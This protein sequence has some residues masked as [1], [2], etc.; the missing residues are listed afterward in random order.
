MSNFPGD[1]TKAEELTGGNVKIL[2]SF[3]AETKQKAPSLA[4][5]EKS[6]VESPPVSSPKKSAG[7]YNSSTK[8]QFR[9]NAAPK[10]EKKFKCTLCDFSTERI[11]LLMLHIKNHSSTLGVHTS[12]KYLMFREIFHAIQNS[13]KSNYVDPSLTIAVRKSSVKTPSKKFVDPNDSID[14]DVRKIKESMKKDVKPPA[15]AKKYREKAKTTP[16]VRSSRSAKKVRKLTVEEETKP[17][18]KPKDTNELKN[19]LLADWSD[20]DEVDQK[21]EGI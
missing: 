8:V 4:S 1:V 14:D 9:A 18:E 11:N 7:T 12:G 21:L 10:S 6:F 13:L 16:T 5:P 20:D 3:Q 17:L 15:P 2:D 19:K